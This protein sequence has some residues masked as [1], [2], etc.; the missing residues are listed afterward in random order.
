MVYFVLF[1]PTFNKCP[2]YSVFQIIVEKSLKSKLWHYYTMTDN[3]LHH[4]R[5]IYE[6]NG[7]HQFNYLVQY[8]DN[9]Y[10]EV[11]TLPE[12]YCSANL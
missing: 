1:N 12:G 7:Y 10:Q 4:I 8:N 11:C 9:P 2:W 5:D 3:M 6:M